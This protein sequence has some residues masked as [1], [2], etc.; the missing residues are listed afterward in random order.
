[1]KHI[2]VA[3]LLMSVASCDLSESFQGTGMFSSWHDGDFKDRVDATGIIDYGAEIYLGGLSSGLNVSN[4][5]GS[6]FFAAS[7]YT[8]SL[9]HFNGSIVAES[10]SEGTT[11]D[12]AGMGKLET[13]AYDIGGSIRGFPTGGMNA[14]GVFEI[15]ASTSPA[16][17]AINISESQLTSTQSDFIRGLI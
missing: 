15:H 10:D 12:G 2:L 13:R 4:G 8:I 7:D 11:V 16:P 9:S 17:D 5:L 6:Y 1:M 3:F 14:N